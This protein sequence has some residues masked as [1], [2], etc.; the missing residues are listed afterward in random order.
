MSRGGDAVAARQWSERRGWRRQD[1]LRRPYLDPECG[2]WARDV[3]RRTCAWRPPESLPPKRSAAPSRHARPDQ[4]TDA[5]DPGRGG[6]ALPAVGGGR[7]RARHQRARCASPGS[8]AA[9]TAAQG[10]TSDQNRVKFLTLQWLDHYVEGTGRRRPADTFTYSRIDRARPG[11]A[12][13][14]RHRLPAH[15]LYPGLTGIVHSGAFVSQGRP[16]Q[17]ANPPNGTPAAIS[18]LPRR[19]LACR[20]SING[21]STEL[22]GQHGDWISEPVD[23]R[24]ERRWGADGPDPGRVA[25]RRGDALRQAVRR[26][27][28]RPVQPE[29]R[30]DRADPPDRPA[31]RHLPGAAGDRDPARDRAQHR[32]GAPAAGHHRRRR[33]VIPRARPSRSLYTV[34]RRGCGHPAP[35][36]GDRRSPTADAIW[37]IR[38]H[39]FWWRCWPW[40]WSPSSCYGR[41]RHRRLDRRVVAEHADT[42]FVRQRSCARSTAT[43]SPSRASTSPWSGVRWSGMLGPN[44]AGKTT[45]LRVLMGLTQVTAGEILI[46]GHTLAPGAPVLS[47][48]GSLVE[49]P[50]FLPHLTGEENL[51]AYWKRDGPA[52]GRRPV[53]GGAGDRRA[54][55]RDRAAGQGVQPRHEAAPGR[56]PV[57]A[58]PAR[59]A[60]ARRADRRARPA[61]DRRDAA[62]AAALCH[63]WP[64]GAG[65]QPPAGRGGADLHPRRGDAQ[66]RRGRLRAGGRHRRRHPDHRLRGVRCGPGVQDARPVRRRQLRARRRAV[67]GRR[68]RRA[69]PVGGDQRPG[70]GGCRHRPGGA[71][72]AGS[73]TR[74]LPW[75]A[76]RPVGSGDR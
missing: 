70:A 66:G 40:A 3:L 68:A 34:A 8:P 46:F 14:A 2:R 73:K 15:R 9:T 31:R 48:I 23:R 10:P 13:P 57:H 69:E 55:R 20:P 30:A 27:S 44:G 11:R 29:Q 61:P 17:I 39:R 21:V 64:R 59:A 28:E 60:G 50:G 62:G 33:P 58:R 54:G 76:L 74:S 52:V 63:R 16:Q 35:A 7:Q 45:S 32:A 43:S 18:S 26:R 56:R 47:R 19:R 51:R 5:A 72:G 24:P 42:P 12:G 53:R 1:V 6:L 71:A 67:A 22:P 37:L 49:G 75:W 25:D 38:A 36:A 41:M 65:L 4:G